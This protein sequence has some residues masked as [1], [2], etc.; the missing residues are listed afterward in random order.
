[1]TV[2]TLSDGPRLSPGKKEEVV[3]GSLCRVL[4]ATQMPRYNLLMQPCVY[5]MASRRRGTLYIG[6]TTEL[7]RRAWEHREGVIAGFTKRYGVKMLV[8]FEL[9]GSLESA[10]VREKQLKEWRRLWKVQLIESTN[11]TWRDLFGE[12][13]D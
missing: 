11:P 1:V 10:L 6:A 7:A 2:T 9:H 3:P 4:L 12:I 5:I 8:W 13:M